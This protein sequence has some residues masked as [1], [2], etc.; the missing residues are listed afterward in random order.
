METMEPKE[1]YREQITYAERWTDG[2]LE[3]KAYKAMI[4]VKFD[5]LDELVLN[6]EPNQVYNK[7]GLVIPFPS[8]FKL[9]SDVNKNTNCLII[10]E[11][12]IV[13]KG[14]KKMWRVE[15]VFKEPGRV[16]AR[17]AICKG[18]FGTKS[19]VWI[20]KE[21]LMK[22]TKRSLFVDQKFIEPL[23]ETLNNRINR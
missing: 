10:V 18:K 20:S 15:R 16:S 21:K 4:K 2:I 12:G 14:I 1:R 6:L 17:E 13:R 11:D 3:L 22:I 9:G 23:Y 8:N 5:A 19:V 7:R